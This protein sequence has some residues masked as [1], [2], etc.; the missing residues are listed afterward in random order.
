MKEVSAATALGIIIA[1]L[2]V[3]FLRPL[4]NGAVGLVLVICIG[5]ANV[6]VAVISRLT[7]PKGKKP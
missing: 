5:I 3:Y 6:I 1:L 2:I 7:S 4:N